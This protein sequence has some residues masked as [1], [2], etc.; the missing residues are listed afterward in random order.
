[1]KNIRRRRDQAVFWLFLAAQWLLPF[2]SILLFQRRFDYGIPVIFYHLLIIESAYALL[3]G[4]ASLAGTVRWLRGRR[5]TRYLLPLVWGVFTIGLYYTY[6]LAWGG[7]LGTGMNMRFTWVAPY[8]LHPSEAISTFGI[9]PFRFWGVLAGVPLAILAV[10]AA[11]ARPLAAVEMR[12]LMWLRRWR[13]GTPHAGWYLG[14]AI[15]L[16]VLA[17]A[18]LAAAATAEGTAA[19]PK[20]LLFGDPVFVS[21]FKENCTMPL[22]GV[23]ST[24]DAL[25]QA[26]TAPTQF[27]KKNV[28]LIVVDACRADHLGLLGYGRDTTPF[29]D[30]LKNSGRLRIVHSYYSASCCTYGGVLT[31]LRSRQWFKMT[32]HGFA[33]QDVLKR[34]GYQVH[35][36]MSGDLSKFCDMQ[37]FYGPSLDSFSDGL[38]KGRHF[39]LNDDRGMFESFGQLAPYNGT[40]SFLYLHLMSVHSLGLRLASSGKYMPYG[41]PMN[42]E[43]FGNNY[44]NGVLQADHNIYEIFAELKRKGYLQNSVVIITGDHGESVGER[45]AYGHGHNLYSEEVNPPLLIYDPEPVAYH[46][47]EFASQVDLAPTILDRLGLPIPPGWDGRSL[48]REDVPRF[49]YLRYGDTY[50][51]V[52]HAPG[53]NTLKY[54]YDAR[55]ETEEVYDDNQDPREQTNIIATTDAKELEAMRKAILAFAPHPEG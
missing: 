39:G 38:D 29:L 15:A 16:V 34:S 10:H 32:L 4:V 21:L 5:A 26:Y 1:M 55:K 48:L 23:D 54:I 17:T 45:G 53:H 19:H 14:G 30:A 7:R 6:L 43:T 33:L 35:F 51:V 12:W 52:D 42:P 46:N 8:V 36:L 31:M 28:I 20:Y 37:S 18:G 50:A 3:L 47:L 13:Q 11:A 9:S 49:A 40:P 27:H 44:D 24:D 41:G 25:G 22:A 2:V